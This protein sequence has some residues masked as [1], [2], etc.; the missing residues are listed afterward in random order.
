MFRSMTNIYFL[1]VFEKLKSP[2][3]NNSPFSFD[4]PSIVW[5]K[6]S[7]LSIVRFGDL[8]TQ[9][10]YK[11]ILSFNTILQQLYNHELEAHIRL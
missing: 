4:T 1:P 9:I 11:M 5:L 7:L 10:I 3:S 2:N 6:R 8:Y